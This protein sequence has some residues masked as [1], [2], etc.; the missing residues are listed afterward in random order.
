MSGSRDKTVRLWDAVTDM[1]LQMLE[2]HSDK[3]DLIAFSIDCKQVMSGSW[4]KT[5][6]PWDAV[7]GAALLRI[8]N[9]LT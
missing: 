6:R 5:V 9:G 7:T 2:G 1:A 8:F 4:D 3:V